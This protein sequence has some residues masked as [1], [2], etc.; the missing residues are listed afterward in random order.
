KWVSLLAPHS[1]WQPGRLL[2][3]SDARPY[4]TMISGMRVLCQPWQSTL[5]GW[6]HL[7]RCDP[8]PRHRL[9]FIAFRVGRCYPQSL[10]PFRGACPHAAGSASDGRAAMI[11]HT[12]AYFLVL[13]LAFATLDDV[14]AA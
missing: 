5:A 12:L 7:G 3:S 14:I 8:F 4:R 6:G 9:Y 13:L 10:P 1:L 11:R 2:R